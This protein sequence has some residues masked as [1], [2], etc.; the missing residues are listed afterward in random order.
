VYYTY[1][2]YTPEGQLFY[3]GKGQRRR[4][5]STYKRNKHWN[6]IV[7]KHGKPDVKILATWDTDAEAFQHE[8]FLIACFRGM[9]CKLS[10]MTDGG[11]GVVG[12]PLSEE[13]KEKIRVSLLGNKYTLGYKQSQETKEKIS[14]SLLNNKRAVG[15]KHT[16]ERRQ[17]MKAL[18][19]G[20]KYAFGNS[21]RAEYKIVATNAAD[22]NKL[23]FVG[24]RALRTAGF[25][26]SAVYCCLN[27]SR[28][29]H[30]GYTWAKEPLENT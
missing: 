1:A 4:A 22:G 12:M 6:S 14:A 20:N 9:G 8:I 7:K 29:R 15:H 2:H 24:T 18:L 21:N 26:H 10:N 30:K 19:K 28:N 27:G 5:Y 17:K 25:T 3:I 23:E 13:H 11:E 16:P